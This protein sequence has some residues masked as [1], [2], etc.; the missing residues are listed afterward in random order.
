MPKSKLIENGW[1]DINK[2]IRMDKKNPDSYVS[3]AILKKYFDD[4]VGQ[5][6]NYE[7]AVALDPNNQTYLTARDE[8]KQG[9]KD[10]NTI[11]SKYFCKFIIS[12]LFV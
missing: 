7:K 6:Y 11:A 9:C 1:R 4:C 2:A 3:R 8:A 12:H 10:L 5:V